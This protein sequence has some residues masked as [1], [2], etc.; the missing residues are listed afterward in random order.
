[1]RELLRTNNPVQLSRIIALLAEDGIHGFVF[2]EHVSGA[3]GGMVD[4]LQRRLMVG[5]DDYAQARR[6]LVEAG[7]PV[8]DE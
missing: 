1:M 3:L 8:P 7:E 4:A 6:L 2:D 5:D